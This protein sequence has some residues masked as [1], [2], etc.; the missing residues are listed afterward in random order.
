MIAQAPETF[1]FSVPPKPF[2]KWAGGKRQLLP[3]LRKALPGLFKH[4]YE[5]FVGGGALFFDLRASGYDRRA[6]LG[7]ANERL[8][9][10]YL[11]VRNGVEAVIQG[12]GKMRYDKREY[13]RERARELDLLEDVELAVWMIYTNRCGFNGL[14]RVNKAGQFNVPFGR[15][16]NPTIC[17]A[18]GL[19]V[20]AQALKRTEF[21]IGDFD[22]TVLGADKGDL[23]YFDPPYIPV[24]GYAD[25]TQYTADGFGA[26]DQ[27]RLR[28]TALRLKGLGVHVIL[29]SADSPALRKLYGK[30]FEI[31]AVSA[32]R[33]INSKV[34]ARGNV[35]EVIVT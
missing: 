32:R 16:T 18:N 1:F 20:A 31:R 27:E 3:E 10:T 11:G 35:G 22:K 15:Y 29:S 30:G 19:R 13:L 25:F 9:H 2:L 17:D 26:K 28:D 8:V 6:T 24:G 7:D 21:R 33:N 34:T 5:P 14:Y 4:Y 23:V 12:L